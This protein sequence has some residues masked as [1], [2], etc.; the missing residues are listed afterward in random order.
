MIQELT[1]E[2][3]SQET[4]EW[5]NQLEIVVRSDRHRRSRPAICERTDERINQQTDRSITPARRSRG[6]T[7]DPTADPVDDLRDE[8]TDRPLH[9]QHRW[10]GGWT[11]WVCHR[12]SPNQLNSR[13]E[14]FVEVS[15]SYFP[16]SVRCQPFQW[17][18]WR[19][20]GLMGAKKSV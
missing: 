15:R 10:A 8:P 20:V 11:C 4:H 14:N 19:L 3:A 17:D 13:C 18:G 12:W 2:R 1:D 7:D 5:I 6:R 9:V 16:G